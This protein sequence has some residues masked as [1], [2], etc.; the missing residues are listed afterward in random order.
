[1]SAVEKCYI[2]T[3]FQ[4]ITDGITADPVENMEDEVFTNVESGKQ[5][6]DKVDKD[7]GTNPN[8]QISIPVVKPSGNPR[9]NI[10]LEQEQI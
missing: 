10:L 2:A 7:E 6:N 3:N 1:M 8:P 5:Q 9:R 4:S